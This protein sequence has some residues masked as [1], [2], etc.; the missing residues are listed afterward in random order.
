MAEHPHLF[1]KEPSEIID[2]TPPRG[3]GREIKIPRRNRRFHGDYLKKRFEKLRKESKDKDKQLKARGISGKKFFCLEI[4]GKEGYD[5]V[6]KSLEGMRQNIRL[7]N[8]RV[9]NNIP[10]AVIEIPYEKATYF[11]KKI[12]DYLEEETNK[13]NPRNKNLIESIEDIRLATLESFWLDNKKFMP[14]GSDSI[15]CEVW[16]RVDDRTNEESNIEKNFFELCSKLGIRHFKEQKIK[17]PERLVVLIE[18]N[19]KQLIDLIETSSHIA[20]FHK[21]KET[22]RFWLEQQN[23]DQTDWV[24]DLKSRLSI[25][26]E[27]EVS[28]CLLDT[29]VNNGH[30]LIAPVLT[31]GNLHSIKPEW[32]TNDNDGHGTLMAGLAIYRNL[33]EAL[34]SQDSIHI[35]HKLESVK[36]I[37]KDGE[38]NDRKLHGDLTQQG[39]SRAESEQ[40][41]NKRII[42]MAVTINEDIN[43][44]IPSS[45]SGALD[46]ITS[47]VDKIKKRLFIVSAGNADEKNYKSYPDSNLSDTVQDPAQSWNAITVG[48]Y[49]NKVSITDSDLK[50]YKL[51]AKIGELSPYSTTSCTWESRWPIKP[52]VVLEGGNMAIDESFATKSDDLSLL[53]LHHKPLENQ[54]SMIDGTSA[55]TAQA[56]WMAAQIQAKYTDIW[57]ETIRALL[58]HSAEWNDA[59][60]RQFYDNK[61]TPKENYKKILRIFGYGIPNLDRA[62]WSYEN[63]LTLIAEQELQPFEKKKGKSGYST[64]DMHFYKMP[65]PRDILKTL[66]DKAKVYLKFTLSYYIEPGPG[67]VGWKD[68]YRYASHGLRF[69]ICNPNENEEQFVKR[70][71][72][73]IKEEDKPNESENSRSNINW[74]LGRQARELGSVHS[75]VWEGTPQDISECNLMAV[76]PIIGWWRERH[77]LKKYN[78]K[79]RYSLIV[80]I[81]TPEEEID[82]YTPVKTKIDARIPIPIST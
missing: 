13:G 63:S 33:E 17:F 59:M 41:Q 66:P 35:Q 49:T 9:V 53:S 55:A 11:L 1:I 81:S 27:S 77:H 51:L 26:E 69:F 76:C 75:D 15:G 58:I 47:G 80:S 61:K 82:L 56:A 6:T 21:A 7:L 4:R 18:A 54:F 5:L 52:E 25:D 64:K 20:E 71:N 24:K 38:N 29:G 28:I 14:Q 78:S 23:K 34:E 16:L 19:K 60:K 73:A 74:R 57:P 8:T 68:K 43:K 30:E 62:I 50:D 42:C 72:K 45:W 67:K 70:I 48:A 3:G 10:I 37:R 40:P 65:W 2:Y 79:A 44:G 31:D 32:G 46:Q 39:I 36:L 12:T 22:A